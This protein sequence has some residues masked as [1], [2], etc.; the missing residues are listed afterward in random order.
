M[1][2]KIELR[3]KAVALRKEGKTYSEIMKIV[4]VAKSTLSE[5]L[6]SVGM[7]KEVKQFFTEKRRLASLRGGQAKRRQRIERSNKIFNLAEGEIGKLS[8]RE[9]WLIG[10]ALYWAEGSKE[11]EG[12]PGS[13]INF[14]NSDPEMIILFLKWLT[15]IVGVKKEEI[16]CEIYT[17]DIFHD[18]VGRFQKFWS[19]K[20]GL[21]IS[22]FKTVYFKRNKI[23]TKRKNIGDLYNGQLRVKVYRSSSLNRQVTGWI[24]GINKYWGIV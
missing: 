7:V 23:N 6:R 5:W 17:H 21:P 15:E 2:V 24:R 12:R 8:K 16:G 22:Y 1:F 9:L 20:T 4:P 13:G 14:S 10:T 18:E 11:K 3:N 19:Q